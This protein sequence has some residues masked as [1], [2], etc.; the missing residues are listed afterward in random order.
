M[1]QPGLYRGVDPTAEFPWKGIVPIIADGPCPPA[2]KIGRR[3]T[4]YRLR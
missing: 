1:G 4:S 3:T 2:H